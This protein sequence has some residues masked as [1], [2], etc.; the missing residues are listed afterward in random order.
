MVG[1]LAQIHSV[2]VE[3]VIAL[4]QRFKMSTVLFSVS[5]ALTK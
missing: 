3:K 2:D 4:L 5:S 1:V